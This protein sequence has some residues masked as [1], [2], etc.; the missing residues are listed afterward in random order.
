LIIATCSSTGGAIC[1]RILVMLASKP[2]A[3][4]GSHALL[5]AG[6]AVQSTPADADSLSAI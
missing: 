2:P 4:T 1:R 3:S 6:A 5:A